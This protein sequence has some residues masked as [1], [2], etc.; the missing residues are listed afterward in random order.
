[1]RV[2]FML[3]SIERAASMGKGFAGFGDFLSTV[4]PGMNGDLRRAGLNVTASEY[5]SACVL[6]ALV[7]G[8]ALGVLVALLGF[9]R[10][11]LALWQAFLMAGMTGMAFFGI[12]FGLH[13]YYPRLMATRLAAGVDQSLV[14][15]LKSL[16][17]QVGSG[18]GLYNAMANVAKANYGMV[19]RE[20]D[21][22]VQDISSGMSE[23]DA[24]EKLALRTRSEYL[25][26]T[27]WQMT[28]SLRTGAS[29]SNAL[30]SLVENMAAYQMRQIKDFAAE[31]NLLILLYLLLAAAVPT[32]GITF[33]VILSS[34][35]GSSVENG[36]IVLAIGIAFVLQ[37]VLIGFVQNRVPRVYA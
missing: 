10:P 22:V 9:T 14:F 21:S 34:L 20:F 2:R 12:F 15:A 18:V 24:L 6:S 5:L 30:A 36:H 3:F 17:I 13:V 25:K 26:K 31:L 27:C 28:T 16:L 29:L 19:S 35:G 37:I 23:A 1:M 7:Y 32:I 33:L 4:F 8:I 11:D